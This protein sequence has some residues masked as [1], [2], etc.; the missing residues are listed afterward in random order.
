MGL[1]TNMDD[2]TSEKGDFVAKRRKLSHWELLGCVVVFAVVRP[3]N[4]VLNLITVDA[5][6]GE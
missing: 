6:T 4:R 5:V 3:T 1:V 2:A